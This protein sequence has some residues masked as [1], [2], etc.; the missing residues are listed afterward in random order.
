MYLLYFLLWMIFFGSIT[1][2]SIL[3]G[4]GVAAAVFAF[5]CVFMDYSIRTELSLYR[6]IPGIIHYLFTLVVEVYRANM[7]VVR[8][9]FEEKQ[10]LEPALV[11][12]DV[13]LKTPEARAFMADSI[14]LTPGTITVSMTDSELVVHCLDESLAEGID[15]SACEKELAKLEEG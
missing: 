11:H 7:Q 15:Q 3:F 4:L 14:T 8:M 2:E 9:I 13:D 5:T 6:K 12:F 1:W 10:K